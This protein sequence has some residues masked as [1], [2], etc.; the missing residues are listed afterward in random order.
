MIMRIWAG[1]FFLLLSLMCKTTCAD[2]HFIP[3]DGITGTFGFWEKDHTYFYS[4]GALRWNWPGSVGNQY[5]R[6]S[7]YWEPA[8]GYVYANNTKKGEND[9]LWIFG[10]SPV[11]E[12][13]IPAYEHAILSPFFEFGIGLAYLSKNKMNHKKLGNHYQFEDRLGFG[14]YFAKRQAALTY[15]YM[16]YSNASLYD[17]N[18]GLD[19]NTFSLTWFF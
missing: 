19:F 8:A 13:Q 18:S 2:V 16:H 7:G 14:F 10:F 12:V 1:L 15:R 11:F 6:I 5:L 9:S 17:N 4:R 3:P